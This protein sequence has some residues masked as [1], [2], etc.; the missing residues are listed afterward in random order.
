MHCLRTKSSQLKAFDNLLLSTPTQSPTVFFE[1][2]S[3]VLIV[4]ESESNS[5]ITV[6]G[7]FN[8]KHLSWDTFSQPNIAGNLPADIFLDFGLTQETSTPTRF[9][10]DGTSKSVLDLF[11]TNRPY[12]V[13]NVT[14]VDQISDHCEV[15]AHLACRIPMP[16]FLRQI[17][18]PDF[19]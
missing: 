4:A 13:I 19:D 8:A 15:T 17:Q 18:L 10:S 11:A 5:V 12:L 7:D 6:L 16:S 3:S 1:T 9:S 2:L 14:V